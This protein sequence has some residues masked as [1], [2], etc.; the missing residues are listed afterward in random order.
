MATFRPP[1]HRTTVAEDD[2]SGQAGK[3]AH[4]RPDVSPEFDQI[5][6]LDQVLLTESSEARLL[7]FLLNVRLH[8]PNTGKALLNVGAE[9]AQ[10][11]LD[12]AIPFEDPVAEEEHEGS[13]TWQREQAP[14]R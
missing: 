7:I 3:D 11:L 10:M 1:S 14:Q 4:Q 13:D 9:G 5:E 8:N 2:R 12:I 6:V